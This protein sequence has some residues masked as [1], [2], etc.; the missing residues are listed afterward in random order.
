[1]L[2]DMNRHFDMFEFVKYSGEDWAKAHDLSF[3]FAS[4]KSNWPYVVDMDGLHMPTEHSKFLYGHCTTDLGLTSTLWADRPFYNDKVLATNSLMPNFINGT[5]VP[6]SVL[7]PLETPGADLADA[8]NW[9]TFPVW[10]HKGHYPC[11]ESCNTKGSGDVPTYRAR[12]KMGS[13]TFFVGEKRSAKEFA[14]KD[15]LRHFV[16]NES[17]FIAAIAYYRDALKDNDIMP[18]LA[19][20]LRWYP[21]PLSNSFAGSI[22]DVLDHSNKVKSYM[23]FGITSKNCE[24]CGMVLQSRKSVYSCN[25]CHKA[26][27]NFGSSTVVAFCALC[28]PEIRAK[29]ARL[30]TIRD[31][32][33][34]VLV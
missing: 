15:L 32:M 24:A 6:G 14:S 16:S 9:L 5:L 7:A 10:A 29:N 26:K 34:S 8:E 25:I 11:V 21:L 13:T 31:S 23:F 28:A 2:L 20:I 22:C 33:L 12:Y 19:H 17:N 30:Q 18:D 1:M 4:L 27:P 3:K